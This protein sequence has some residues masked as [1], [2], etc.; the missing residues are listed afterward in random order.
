MPTLSDLIETLRDQ[1]GDQV[2]RDK[3]N[4]AI[5]T[6][7][8][9]SVTFA[10]GQFIAGASGGT[11]QALIEIELEVMLVTHKPTTVTA[12]VVRG[13]KGTTAATHA[14]A[15]EV[16]TSFR[17]PRVTYRRAINRALD[18]ISQVWGKPSWDE[19]QSFSANGLIPVPA[20]AIR[21]PFFVGS[22]PTSDVDLDM[23]PFTF[24]SSLPT[25]LVATGKGIQLVGFNPGTGKAY[26]G[27]EVIWP[28]LTNLTDNLDTAFPADAADLIE[29]GARAY[30]MDSEVFERVAFT[31]P[32]ARTQNNVGQ[33][34]E[35]RVG[36]RD[37]LQMFITRRAELSARYGH[38]RR[39][40]IKGFA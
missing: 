4:G 37:A 25:S 11:V 29:L 7:T 33:M 36:A 8:G 32:H 28:N 34:G 24:H 14:D 30:L 38:R 13:Y 18:A 19:T 39:A 16:I 31:Q 1:A 5:A 40:W 17:H 6:T 35:I 23:V 22:K 15:T 20:A 2:S 3:L 27:Y 21:P 9:T 26:I 12:T 10:D